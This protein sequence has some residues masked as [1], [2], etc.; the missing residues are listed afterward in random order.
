MR[1]ELD[2]QILLPLYLIIAY[3]LAASACSTDSKPPVA[4]DP[5]SD[6]HVYAVVDPHAVVDVGG[7][8]NGIAKD[9]LAETVPDRWKCAK[10]LVRSNPGEFDGPAIDGQPAPKLRQSLFNQPIELIVPADCFKDPKLI[11]YP[12][13]LDQ[14]LSLIGSCLATVTFITVVV[15]LASK[16]VNR[17][18]IT[19][20]STHRKRIQYWDRVHKAAKDR[21]KEDADFTRDRNEQQKEAE[22]AREWKQQAWGEQ[23]EERQRRQNQ[24]DFTPPWRWESEEE[25]NARQKEYTQNREKA[26]EEHQ[27]AQQEEDAK[28]RAR[29]KQRRDDQARADEKKRAQGKKSGG[30][31]T[32][33]GR[34]RT[35]KKPHDGPSISPR[36]REIL[37]EALARDREL[38]DA[39]ASPHTRRKKSMQGFHPGKHPGEPEPYNDAA[40]IINAAFDDE[41]LGNSPFQKT[42]RKALGE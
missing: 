10:A 24:E 34:A 15:G 6:G 42:V 20:K 8:V 28:A 25:Y 37:Q 33:G 36:V 23:E 30:G 4:L 9:K 29:E 22:R 17:I 3:A 13:T 31:Q 19:P 7:V 35:E 2:R 32:W 11:V 16:L 41:S 18:D 26:R 39:G 38:S 21:A 5:R 12:P 1:P 40:A 14:I 27:S